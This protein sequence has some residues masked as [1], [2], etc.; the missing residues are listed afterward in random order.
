MGVKSS[1]P[2]LALTHHIIV[3]QSAINC[4]LYGFDDYVILG[5]D[6][7]IN[8]A[9]VAGQ[10]K[11]IMAKLGLELSPYKSIESVDKTFSTA[12]ICKRLFINGRD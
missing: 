5:D 9:D 6:I 10:Y 4:G 12:E 2:M 7:V 1:F 3:R 8:N 11:S